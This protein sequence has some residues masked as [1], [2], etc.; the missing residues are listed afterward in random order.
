[1]P[2]IKC[3]H[4]S[5]KSFR[6]ENGLIWHLEHIHGNAKQISGAVSNPR[7]ESKLHEANDINNKQALEDLRCEI[8]EKFTSRQDIALRRD[9][10]LSDRIEVLERIAKIHRDV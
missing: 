1:M 5:H 6:T 4:C 8:E 2:S 10:W 7:L 9:S 3:P